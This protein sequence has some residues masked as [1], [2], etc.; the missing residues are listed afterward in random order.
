MKLPLTNTDLKKMY[1]RKTD[2]RMHAFGDTDLDK[3][4]IRVNKKK[5]K[6]DGERGEVLD[7][8]VHEVSHAK[9]PKMH[10]KNVR[11]HTKRLIK[12]LNRKHKSSYYRLFS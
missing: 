9:H 10:E 6:K 5:S 3:K 12:K 11:K 8:I 4:V 1:K 2:N 7:T